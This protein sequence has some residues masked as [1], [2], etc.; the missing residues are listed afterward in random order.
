MKTAALFFLLLVSGVSAFAQE[1]QKETSSSPGTA[2]A[3]QGNALMKPLALMRPVTYTDRYCAGFI[4][5]KALPRTRF[6]TGSLNSPHATKLGSGDVV[7]VSGKDLRVGMQ[8]NIVREL[9]DSNESE[10]F[11]GQRRLIRRT[12]QPYAEVGHLRVVDTRQT[13]A[14]AV[15]EFGCKAA[16]PGDLL[17]PFQERPPIPVRGPG[18]VDRFAPANGN[19]SGRILM[20]QD[21]DPLLGVGQKVY[22]DVGAEKGVKSGEV[23]RVFRGP[24]TELRDEVDAL[25]Y[26]STIMEDSQKHPARI[27]TG[28]L[29]LDPE[30]FDVG[31]GP[32]IKVQDLPRRILG[33]LVIL[34]VTPSSATGMITVALEDIHAGDGVEAE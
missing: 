21:S 9:R 24:G 23:F 11:P 4:E 16:V 34:N 6:I 32:K 17:V 22:L 27:R 13:M 29:S 8:F 1:A 28:G 14:I 2:G 15:I 20:A 5:K 25:S 30:F 18:M 7:Y 33:E 26:K 19:L 10:L 3:Q 31:R 12:G